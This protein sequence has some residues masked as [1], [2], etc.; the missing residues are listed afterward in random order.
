MKIHC[1]PLVRPIL[2]FKIAI[3]SLLTLT[4]L[5]LSAVILLPPS[6]TSRPTTQINDSTIALAQ[7]IQKRLSGIVTLA[8]GVTNATQLQNHQPSFENV[9]AK[10]GIKKRG[11]SI[12]AS[13]SDYDRD[14]QLDLFVFGGEDG[15]RLFR[16]NKGIFTDVTAKSGITIKRN[17]FAGV[18]GDYDNDGCPDLYIVN[19]ASQPTSGDM[20]ILYHNNCN[21]TFTNVS[22]KS[23]IRDTYHGRGAAWADY[24][25]DGYLD[26]YVANHGIQQNDIYFSE[27]NILYLNNGNGTFRDITL[28]SKVSGVAKC[29]DLHDQPPD[30]LKI[31][32]GPY[33]ESF[34]PIWFDYNNDGRPDLFVSTDSGVSPLYKNNGDGTFTDVTLQAGLCRVASGMGVTAG[35]FNNDGYLDLYVTNTGENFLWKNN[36]DGTFTNVAPDLNLSDSLSIGWG[37]G[38]LDYDNDGNL[39]LY[40]VDGQ[41]SGGVIWNPEIGKTRVDRLYRNNGSGQFEEVATQEGISIDEPKEAAA[42]ADYNGDGFTDIMVTGG[43]TSPNSK[44]R[45]Y[46]NQG[47]SNHWITIKLRGTVSNRDAVGARITLKAGLKTQIREVVSG[48]SFVSQNSLWQTFGLGKALKIESLEV[49]WPNGQIQKLSN[50]SVNQTLSLMEP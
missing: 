34:Q 12:G 24:N 36:G 47:N 11:G 10:S 2:V 13:W 45:L 9:I 17:S 15:N 1:L 27:P 37:A 26:L 49:K 4:I 46:L 42:F 31:I 8:R 23:G 5:A 25:G 19:H 35:D 44:N 50:I 14:G 7:T 41:V 3:I 38:F 21:G 16:Q 18:F 32:N 20:D 30:K 40:V 43:W 6:F 48:S 22:S 29:N 39:D 33:K 28:E